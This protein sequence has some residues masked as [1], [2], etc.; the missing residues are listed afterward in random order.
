MVV[1]VVNNR[2]RKKS[3]TRGKK[4]KK[5]KK[6]PQSNRNTIRGTEEKGKKKS[7]GV[8][9][10][11]ETASYA[12][13]QRKRVQESNK[14]QKQIRMDTRNG[15]SQSRVI[16]VNPRQVRFTFTHLSRAATVV[17]RSHATCV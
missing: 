9:A 12:D 16:R 17:N 13:R 8:C 15:S 3:N 11:T 14:K 10:E 7:R 2:K 4:G 5:K 6:S 1:G